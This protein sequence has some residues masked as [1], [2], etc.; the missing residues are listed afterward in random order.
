MS[1]DIAGSTPAPVEN[2]P[3]SDAVV[4]PPSPVS[5]DP[6]NMPEP[7]PA[8]DRAKDSKDKEQPDEAKKTVSTRD[9]LKK[10]AEKVA[11]KQAQEEAEAK[12]PSLDTAKADEKAGEQSK[13]RPAS[14]DQGKPATEDGKKPDPQPDPSKPHHQPPARFKSDA[15]ATAEW[16]NAPESVK[17]A[18]HRTVR[19]L[20]A[21]IEKH[22]ASAEAFEQIKD[23]DDLAKRN[24]TTIRDAMTRYT[25]LERTLLTNPL[26]GIQEVC[27]YAGIS[28]RDLAAHVMGQRPE[29][30]QS[31]NDATIRELR[32]QITALQQQIGGVTGSLQNQQRSAI[33]QTLHDFAADHPRFE[34]LADDIALLL[35]SKR[36]KDLAEAYEM[37]ERLNPAPDV[38]KAQA[39]PQTRTVLDPQAQTLKGSKSVSGAPSTGSDPVTRQRSTSIKDSLRKAAAKVG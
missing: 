1:D 11:E 17:A 22:R 35:E 34:E 13:D 28:L 21:G 7:K 27:E 12:K 36:A 39:A 32:Q 26:Q 20:E 14:V 16:Q 23:F 38:A 9:A 37:A 24:N 31:Q 25:A 18:V 8:E 3:V 33:N 19:E 29:Q 2:A 10:A 30:V 5:T 6:Q 15:A 4:T